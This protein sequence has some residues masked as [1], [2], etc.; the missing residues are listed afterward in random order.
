MTTK[1]LIEYLKEYPDDSPM[2]TV[3]LD[4]KAGLVY[5][6]RHRFAIT[7]QGFPILVNDINADETEPMEGSDDK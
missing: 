5:Q 6:V 1:E 3:V 4:S 2:S 7:D